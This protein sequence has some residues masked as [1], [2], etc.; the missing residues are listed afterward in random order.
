VP[1]TVH[2]PIAHSLKPGAADHFLFRVASDKSAHYEAK[3]SIH[4]IDGQLVL[5]QKLVLDIFIPRSAAK[6]LV[7]GK[8]SE[9]EPSGASSSKP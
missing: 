2:V 1:D 7:K 8:G 5:E 9:V 3:V 6:R 4:S